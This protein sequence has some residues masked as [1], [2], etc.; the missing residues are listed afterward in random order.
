MG[1]KGKRPKPTE[2]ERADEVA[3]ELEKAREE[4][5]EFLRASRL[6]DGWKDVRVII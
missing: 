5:E 4:A 1:K 3:R 2:E 6:P